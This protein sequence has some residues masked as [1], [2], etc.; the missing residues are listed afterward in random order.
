MTTPTDPGT[1]ALTPSQLTNQLFD[2]AL[3][4]YQDP[5]EAARQV[6]VFISEALVYAASSTAR[7]EPSRV[8][9]LKSLGE[10]IATSPPLKSA[11][12]QKP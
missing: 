3:S 7:D 6:I 9:L 10:S 4:Q 5:T 2:A 11:L 12:P 8:A 1:Q